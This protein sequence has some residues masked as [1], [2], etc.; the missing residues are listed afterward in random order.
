MSPFPPLLAEAWTDDLLLDVQST[1]AGHGFVVDRVAPGTFTYET[2]D[3]V[4]SLVVARH[5]VRR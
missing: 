1:L 4:S 3:V 5:R 2:S